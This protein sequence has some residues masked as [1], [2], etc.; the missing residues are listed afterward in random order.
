MASRLESVRA[1]VERAKVIAGEFQSGTASFYEPGNTTPLFVTTCRMKKPKPSSFEAGN[2]TEWSTKKLPVLKIPLE[3]PG[4]TTIR[5]GLIVQISTPDGDPSINAISF[6][7]QSSLVGQF[8]AE[9]EINLA[10]EVNV[11]ERIV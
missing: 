11:T 9:R 8:A 10:T 4:V 5:K 1:A 6:T 2:Q 7:V 3:I